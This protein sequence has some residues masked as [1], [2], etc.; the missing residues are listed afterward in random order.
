MYN[1]YED[2]MRSVLGY[3]NHQQDNNSWEYGSS[4]N[5]YSEQY[6]QIASTRNNTYKLEQMYP[7]VYK[8]INP[9]VC[10]MCNNNN[11]PIT[12]DLINQMTNTI[13]DNVV[14]RVEIDKIINLNIDLSNSTNN[15]SNVE[16]NT[17][18]STSECK[19]SKECCKDSCKIST[20][21]NR[22]PM[23]PPPPPGPGM[24]GGG[25]GRPRPPRNPLLLDLIRILL[26]NR[27]INQNPRP[28]FPPRPR[29]SDN[30]I[31]YGVSGI[32]SGIMPQY[33]TSSIQ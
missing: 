16:E 3:T 29:V 28:P 32:S 27:L 15:R 11:Q 31:P 5:G 33:Y 14:N 22:S 24:P 13:Y 7:Q 12:E 20:S 8:V 2:Y 18:N 30:N 6:N 25:G 23:P 19:N 9:V 10:S 21:N 17:V 26:L 1:S 4:Y